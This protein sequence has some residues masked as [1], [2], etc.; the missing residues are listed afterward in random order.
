MPDTTSTPASCNVRAIS[1]APVTF[2]SASCLSE[3]GR[4]GQATVDNQELTVDEL[5]VGARQEQRSAGDVVYSAHPPR[6]DAGHPAL[7]LLRGELSAHPVR[8]D[9]A[10]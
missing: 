3:G 5:G 8:R 4:A 1:S 10:G 6:G 9:R 7:D 2:M